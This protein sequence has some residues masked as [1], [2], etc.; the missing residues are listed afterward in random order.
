VTADIHP[1][2]DVHRRNH[3]CRRMDGSFPVVFLDAQEMGGPVPVSLN[4]LWDAVQD[5]APLSQEEFDARYPQ[6][7]VH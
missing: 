4:L 5:T 2:L 3:W 6:E 1:A 7:T